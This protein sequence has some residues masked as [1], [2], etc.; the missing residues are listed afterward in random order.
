MVRWTELQVG[1]GLYLV[2][3]CVLPFLRHHFRWP[4]AVAIML[5]PHWCYFHT[6]LGFPF[7]PV[8][9]PQWAVIAGGSNC[10]RIFGVPVPQSRTWYVADA[11]SR[12]REWIK[13][14][15]KS[16]KGDV[17][18]EI[19]FLSFVFKSIWEKVYFMP[20]FPLRIYL[21]INS[22]VLLLSIWQ[23]EE[24]PG[25]CSE[26][27]LWSQ[28][29][30]WDGNSEGIHCCASSLVCLQSSLCRDSAPSW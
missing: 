28:M 21:Y 18:D 15:D 9:S 30:F 24:E 4:V 1:T 7:L 8:C 16:I 11:Q 27:S 6:G 19:F 20:G 2:L 29:S 3:S 14:R 10:P 23:I 13:G 17:D 25:S 12:H 5:F 22:T 26:P